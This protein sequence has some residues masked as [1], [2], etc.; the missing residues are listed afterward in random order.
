MDKAL[1]ELEQ[2]LLKRIEEWASKTPHAT[3]QAKNCASD[4]AYDLRVWKLKFKERDN[5]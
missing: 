2:I 5:G 1:F 4:L 3:G